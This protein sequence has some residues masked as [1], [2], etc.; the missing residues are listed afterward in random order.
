MDDS[1]L[2]Y[3][4]TCPNCSGTFSILLDRIPPVQARFRCP[5]C[6][7]PMDFPSREEARV[8]A[9][10]QGESAAPA[11]KPTLAP[12]PPPPAPVSPPRKT[13]SAARESTALNA[14]ANS[15]QPPETAR[16]RIEKLGFEADEYDRRA[17]RNLI[18]TGEVS[19][20]D[21]IRVDF[22]KPVRAADL[23][24][25]KSL[26]SLRKTATVQPPVCCRTHTDK[27]AFFKCKS[28]ERPLC[29]EC[30]QEKKFGGTTIRVCQHCGGTAVDLVTLTT[31]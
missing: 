1:D 6:K 15:N 28:T 20:N 13:T 25:L 24:Y 19:E 22:G 29:E 14:A 11:A 30:A 12:E 5:H 2:S 10:L 17:I 4:F 3:S 16:F 26:F 9:K 31:T 27:V 7:Q 21:W 23:P 18:R 8:Y